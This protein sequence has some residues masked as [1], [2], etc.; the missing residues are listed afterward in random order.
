M[1]RTAALLSVEELVMQRDGGCCVICG[2]PV[3]G[4]R[5]WGWSIH[6]RRGRDRRPDSN[7]VQN[8]ILVCGS[9]NVDRCHGRI[10]QR[11]SESQ[12]AGWWL[13]RIA[14]TDPLTAPVL[15]GGSRWVYL[16]A[17]GQ[18][19]DEPPMVGAA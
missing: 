3:E 5:A 9:S 11:R 14:G 10:H 18:Y 12:P 16:T 15:I 17:D 7:S 6:H 13:S 4:E 1:K 19:S 2:D 8:L